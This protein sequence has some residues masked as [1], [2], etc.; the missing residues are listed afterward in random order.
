MQ[1]AIIL[2]E[3]VVNKMLV[4]LTT[5]IVAVILLFDIARS[6]RQK[7]EAKETFRVTITN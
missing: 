2:Y 7:E 1:R 3:K 4:K 6:Q 5:G